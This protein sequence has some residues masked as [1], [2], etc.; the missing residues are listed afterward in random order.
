VE[1]ARSELAAALQSAT[2]EA[3]GSLAIT[4]V[5][6]ADRVT[7]ASVLE[8]L[9]AAQS[10]LAAAAGVD[11]AEA[12]IETAGEDAGNSSEGALAVVP[13]DTEELR[14]AAEQLRVEADNIRTETERVEAAGDAL[15]EAQLA[16]A[17]GAREA[18]ATVIVDLGGKAGEAESA[19]LQQTI[20][21]LDPGALASGESDLPTLLG[22]LGAAWDALQASVTPVWEDI[23][24]TW[25]GGDLSNCV[26]I[27][28][29]RVLDRQA[30]VKFN[31]M[32]EGCFSGGY[33]SDGPTGHSDML[34]CPAGV[35]TPAEFQRAIGGQ[36]I[37]VTDDETQDCW[38]F[39]QVP[40]V[41]AFFRQ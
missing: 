4:T 29:G 32:N 20:D 1:E 22:E 6:T 28:K 11:A 13:E 7:D 30:S 5:V 16:V 24:G 25:C 9:T 14:E 17:D 27:E 23:N 8:A 41:K 2:G 33:V 31:E 26:T 38:W 37:F 19:H 3:E 39:V 36:A 40:G 34:Y 12:E 21:A 15:W 18:A 35:P 10:E